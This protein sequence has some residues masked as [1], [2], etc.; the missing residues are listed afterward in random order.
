VTK[1][2]AGLSFQSP[3]LC[4]LCGGI[5]PPY[6]RQ[7]TGQV[8]LFSPGPPQTPSSQHPLQFLPRQPQSCGHVKQTSPLPEF[9][10]DSL[11]P[12]AKSDLHEDGARGPNHHEYG[13]GRG[14]P[15]SESDGYDVH[16]P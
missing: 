16:G 9:A 2:P 13:I 15:A 1:N 12:G 4:V 10:A 8:F 11:D 7:F 5:F 3:T 14:L 6:P